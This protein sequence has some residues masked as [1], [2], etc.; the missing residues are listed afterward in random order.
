MQRYKIIDYYINKDIKPPASNVLNSSRGNNS[1]GVI[2]TASYCTPNYKDN[3]RAD[4][5]PPPAEDIGY[6]AEQRQY[7]H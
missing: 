2:Y 4:Q 7:H 5:Y 6:L 1:A 3:Y